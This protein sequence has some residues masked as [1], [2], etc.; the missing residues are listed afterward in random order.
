MRSKTLKLIYIKIRIFIKRLYYSLLFLRGGI[1]AVIKHEV[2]HIRKSGAT[3]VFDKAFLELNLYQILGILVK[4]VY[5]LPIEEVG[6]IISDIKDVIE[7]A[8]I[9]KDN[10][11]ESDMYIG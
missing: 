11:Q 9:P 7:R 5:G 3:D 10:N 2:Q 8:T 4:E 6:N 1:P